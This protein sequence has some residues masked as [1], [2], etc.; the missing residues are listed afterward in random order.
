VPIALT[1][2]MDLSP[3]RQQAIILTYGDAFLFPRQENE[4]WKQAFA[5]SPQRVAMPRRKQG[6]AI[7][8]GPDGQTVYLTSE[9]LPA[10][11]WEV[12]LPTRSRP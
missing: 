11:L 7:C 10:P 4:S 8:F 2:G 1:V 3:D 12:R 9:K 5:R 6:E